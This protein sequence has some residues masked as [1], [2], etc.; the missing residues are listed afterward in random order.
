MED[1]HLAHEPIPV[2][3]IASQYAQVLTATIHRL[4]GPADARKLTLFPKDG[5]HRAEARLPS[6]LYRVLVSGQ[7]FRTVA[8]TRSWSS[9]PGLGGVTAERQHWEVLVVAQGRRAMDG[10]VY[11]GFGLDDA[12]GPPIE[13]E[14]WA[15]VRSAIYVLAREIYW[16]DAAI[17]KGAIVLTGSVTSERVKAAIAALFHRHVGSVR[18]ELEVAAPFEPAGGVLSRKETTFAG[19][20]DP[21]TRHPSITP[22]NAARPGEASSSRLTSPRPPR[23]ELRAPRSPSP[24]CRWIG[25]RSGST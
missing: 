12:G 11:R 25:R 16:L 7:A 8:Q 19:W 13:E 22:E 23:P 14:P 10:I 15:S 9:T 20:A 1:A 18:N 5:V 2:A 17:S 24:A 6:G 3:A 4:D 21:V